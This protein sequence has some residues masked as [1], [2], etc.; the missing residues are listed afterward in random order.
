[1]DPRSNDL[2]LNCCKQAI[3]L[4][5]QPRTSM[6]SEMAMFRQLST[7]IGVCSRIGEGSVASRKSMTILWLWAVCRHFGSGV[8]KN[9]GA[10]GR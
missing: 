10:D 9:R 8:P 7:G 3:A 1:M 4:I 6:M 2:S 5:E